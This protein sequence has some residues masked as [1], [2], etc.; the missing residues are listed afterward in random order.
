MN[1]VVNSFFALALSFALGCGSVGDPPATTLTITNKITTLPAGQSHDFDIAEDHDQGAG[2]TLNLT[3]QGTLVQNG[4]GATYIAPSSPPSP[5]SITVTA[6]AANGSGVSDSDT[7][8]ISAAGG[9]VVSISP[10]TFGAT[11]GGAPVTLNVSVTQ[12]APSDVLTGG[13]NGSPVCNGA[14][15]SLGPFSGAPGGGAYTVQ[16]FPPNSVTEA[17]Q[18]QVSVLSNLANATMGKAYVTIH[19]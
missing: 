8:S 16:Y 15:G 3:G 17:T 7:F 10:S 2:F 13:V 11:A 1:R 9:P 14:C 19:P 4:P 6:T 18:Q 12:D 5:N